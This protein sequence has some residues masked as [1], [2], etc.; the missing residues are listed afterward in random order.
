MSAE[1]PVSIMILLT[2][3]LAIRADTTNASSCSGP[4]ESSEGKVISGS[5]GGWCS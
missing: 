2:C 3:A 1:L 5:E 4:P